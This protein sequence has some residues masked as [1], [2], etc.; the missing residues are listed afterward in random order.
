MSHLQII[1]DDQRAA[2][3]DAARE[4]ADPSSSY[5]PLQEQVDKLAKTRSLGLE[6]KYTSSWV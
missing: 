1:D 2:L 3:I 6:G 5:A 4:K